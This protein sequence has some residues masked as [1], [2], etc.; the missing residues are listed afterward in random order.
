M[1]KVNFLAI[2]ALLV[3]GSLAFAGQQKRAEG[4][5]G[6][7]P[8]TQMYYNINNLPSGVTYQCDLSS[9]V[10]TA[11]YDGDPNASGSFI[12]NEK[13]DGTFSLVAP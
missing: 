9:Q 13:V 1:K 12:R 6:F 7:D 8:Q 10:C 11:I 2:A 3:A 4:E 5:W